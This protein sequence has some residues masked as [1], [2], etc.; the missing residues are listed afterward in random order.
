MG[1]CQPLADP[2]SSPQPSCT[3]LRCWSLKTGECAA[4]FE[5]LLGRVRNVSTLPM[6]GYSP[7]S[8]P[9]GSPPRPA[10]RSSSNLKARLAAAM[11][12]GA[13]MGK[14]PP[15]RHKVTLQPVVFSTD[16]GFLSGI[17]PAKKEA[18]RQPGPPVEHSSFPKR[19]HWEVNRMLQRSR[20]LAPPVAGGRGAGALESLEEHGPDSRGAAA[21]GG[22]PDGFGERDRHTRHDERHRGG[23]RVSVT[24]AR[25]GPR[26]FHPHDDRSPSALPEWGQPLADMYIAPPPVGH[27]VTVSTRLNI[28][29]NVDEDDEEGV[30]PDATFVV[31]GSGNGR[32]HFF[33][34][35]QAKGALS[36]GAAR[37]SSKRR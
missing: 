23:N 1:L 19:P 20:S 7:P 5:S 37:N 18:L 31:A 8:S 25:P 13:V 24:I 15:P 12:A 17:V 33:K 28:T 26:Q 10:S 32:M 36:G 3:Q 16:G 30:G 21:G 35:T 29:G 9:P 6:P 11:T 14:P 34:Y 27:V 4:A 22:V 2:V